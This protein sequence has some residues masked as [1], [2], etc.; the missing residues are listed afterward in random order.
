MHFN[1][2]LVSKS[3][4]HLQ[5]SCQNKQQNLPESGTCMADNTRTQEKTKSS[6]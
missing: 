4:S 6:L 2:L 3:G 5:E 1:I